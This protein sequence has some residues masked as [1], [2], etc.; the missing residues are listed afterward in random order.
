MIAVDASVLIAYLDPADAH[1]AA[2]VD[3]LAEATPP[4]L[5]HPLTAAEVLVAPLRRAM[6]D[7]VW[8]TL[9]AIGVEVDD[10]PLDPWQL[11][12]LR[13]GTGLK[14]PDCCVL[15]T[16]ATHRCPVATFDDRLARH[17]V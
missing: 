14:M 3:L 6:A 17:A 5:V 1:H 8:A 16:A 4:L 13:V 15:A 9:T 12:E 2:A 7:D 10:A 11:A